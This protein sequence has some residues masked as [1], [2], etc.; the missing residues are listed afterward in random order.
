MRKAAEEDWFTKMKIT[1]VTAVLNRVE[2][3][4]QSTNSVLSQSHTDVELLVQDGGSSDGTLDLLSD[5]G[6]SRLQLVSEPDYGIYDAINRGISRASGEVVGVMHSD[7]FFA[8][9]KVLEHV[10]E[11]FKDE[12]IDGVFGDLEYVSA[13]EPQNVIRRWRAGEYQV[14]KLWWGWMPPHPTLYLRRE[15][16]EKFGDYNEEYRIAADYEA[17]LRWLL[18]AN[19]KLAYL[20]EVMVKMRVG[21]ESNRSIEHLIQKSREDYRSIRAHRVGGFI[22]LFFKN[23][24]KLMQFFPQK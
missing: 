5:I 9:E 16:F 3:I 1:I 20:P 10:A 6:D 17:I 21:G 18:R 2:T 12:S 4:A 19:I 14:R 11:I 7:D 24:N 22:T 23:V 8:H 13:K 15:V